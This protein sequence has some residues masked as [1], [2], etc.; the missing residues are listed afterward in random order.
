PLVALV[1]DDDL[2]A[3]VEEGQLT[4]TVTQR[5]EGETR[6]FEDL[7]IRLEA[8]DRPMFLR[9]L[10]C[11]QLGRADAAVLIALRPPLAV[12]GKLDFEPF[13]QRVDDRYADAVQTAGHLVGRVLELAAGVQDREDDFG[14]RLAALLVS[15]DRDTATV[16]AD[17]T[18]TVRV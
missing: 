8:D 9:V 4:Q 5:I 18:R 2:Q 1:R 14:R 17:R 11:R 10:S 6:L 3:F 7:G 13:A 16:V 15:V 12:P